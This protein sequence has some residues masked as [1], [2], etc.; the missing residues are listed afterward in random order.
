MGVVAD[1]DQ[2]HQRTARDEPT[3]GGK[4]AVGVRQ[5]HGFRFLRRPGY[6]AQRL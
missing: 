1:N 2:E 5:S 6:D 4:A 3:E